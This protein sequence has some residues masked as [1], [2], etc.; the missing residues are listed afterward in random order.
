MMMFN[1]NHFH[2]KQK[3]NTLPL[4]AFQLNSATAAAETWDL[5]GQILRP[6]RMWSWIL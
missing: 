2:V 3:K 6:G 5:K 4:W 1:L